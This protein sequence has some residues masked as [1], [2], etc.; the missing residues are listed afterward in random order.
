M[1][2]SY[3]YLGAGLHFVCECELSFA[4]LLLGAKMMIQGLPFGPV[5]VS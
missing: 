1:L 3:E 4:S 5:F 2:I